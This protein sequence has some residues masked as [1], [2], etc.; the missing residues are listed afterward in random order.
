MDST[1]DRFIQQEVHYTKL[2]NKKIIEFQENYSGHVFIYNLLKIL[3]LKTVT[4]LLLTPRKQGEYKR[5]HQPD[6]YKHS[7]AI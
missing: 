7:Q 6:R 4:T 3:H 2:I 1:V 5:L